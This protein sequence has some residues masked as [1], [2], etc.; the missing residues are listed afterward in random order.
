[1]YCGRRHDAIASDCVFAFEAGEIV[2]VTVD[3]D[4]TVK[5]LFL[6]VLGGHECGKESEEE[7]ARDGVS[8]EDS[9][10]QPGGFSDPKSPANENERKVED[11]QSSSDGD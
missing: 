2:S 9:H 11:A 7:N 3:R 4:M 10:D 5:W 8:T 1:M 6:V